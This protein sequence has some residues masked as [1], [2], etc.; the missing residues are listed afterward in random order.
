RVAREDP[1]ECGGL[2]GRERRRRHVV[3]QR[4]ERDEEQVVPADDVVHEHDR[5][6]I[7]SA[8]VSRPPTSRP[9][10]RSPNAFTSAT[11]WRPNPGE[12]IRSTPTCRLSG[13]HAATR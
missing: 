12:N 2:P 1:R 3:A 10:S 11:T 8:Y 5:A 7:C 4:I 9:G 6:A 13:K